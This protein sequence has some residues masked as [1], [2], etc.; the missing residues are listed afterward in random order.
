[1]HFNMIT[2]VV[3]PTFAASVSAKTTPPASQFF[4]DIVGAWRTV[5]LSSPNT[6]TAPP[7][8]PDS[9][10]RPDKQCHRDDERP[11]NAQQT[12]QRSPNRPR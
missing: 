1:M 3:A 11:S 9:S 2:I 10:Q 7:I 8:P 5:P 6:S 12:I 4:S